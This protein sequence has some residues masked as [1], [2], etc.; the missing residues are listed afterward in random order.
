MPHTAPRQARRSATLIA[1]FVALMGTSVLTGWALDFEPLKRVLPGMVAMNP[2]TAIAFL[3]AAGS[4]LL[5]ARS[6]G[7]Q[8]DRATASWQS[9]GFALLAAGIYTTMRYPP[10]HR[11]AAFGATAQ[12][13]PVSERL[14]ETGLNLPLHPA[15][16]DAD[17]EQVVAA[18]QGF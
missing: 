7:Q 16:S 2:V 3:L 8:P 15:L 10:L 5:A 17:V 4:L 14:A 13:L 12:R 1:V 9:S 6:S 11:N 18:V